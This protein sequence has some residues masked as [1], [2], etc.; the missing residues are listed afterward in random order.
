[1][2]DT[3]TRVTNF[4]ELFHVHEADRSAKEDDRKRVIEDQAKRAGLS[5]RDYVQKLEAEKME[6]ERE[7]IRRI[8]GEDPVEEEL[9]EQEA[10][11]TRTETAGE[12]KPVSQS[13]NIN[14]ETAADHRTWAESPKKVDMERGMYRGTVEDARQSAI[15]QEMELKEKRRMNILQ[16]TEDT[17]ESSPTDIVSQLIDTDVSLLAIM[18]TKKEDE[19]PKEIT[20]ETLLS[21]FIFGEDDLDEAAPDDLD[22]DDDLFGEDTA[23]GGDSPN[24][25]SPISGLDA[26]LG[27]LNKERKE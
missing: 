13:E 6:Y 14:G 5:Y 17:V 11:D 15:Q 18:D 25:D 22:M 1:M 19:Q 12:E 3:V 2:S 24:S 23:T 9:N 4:K 26:F 21:N 7:V 16:A 10:A 8:T 20:V 27:T